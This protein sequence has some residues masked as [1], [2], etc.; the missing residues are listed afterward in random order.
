MQTDMLLFLRSIAYNF[1]RIWFP[2]T[3]IYARY[4]QTFKLFLRAQDKEYMYILA[5]LIGVKNQSELL[6]KIIN[7]SNFYQVEHSQNFIWSSAEFR[8][9]INLANLFKD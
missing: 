1:P 2:R 5:N 6:E 8:T 9:L 7:S 4:G 3:L